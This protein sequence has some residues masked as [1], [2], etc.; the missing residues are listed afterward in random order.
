MC[1]ITVD[2]AAP[3]APLITAVNDNA[4]PVT[5]ELSSGDSTNDQTPILMGT[6]E[7]GSSVAVYDGDTLLKT[8]EAN[9]EGNWSLELSEP[10]AEGEHNLSANATDASGNV[11]DP[12]DA[13]VITHRCHGTGSSGTRRDR[14]HDPRRYR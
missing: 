14:W 6:A 4:E 9:A 12:S 10:L 1:P 5:G 2:A 11:S 8:V 3:E 13:F 7:A